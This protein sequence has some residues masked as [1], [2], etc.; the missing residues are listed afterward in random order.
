MW[1]SVH[2]L[3][4]PILQKQPEF[5]S[6]IKHQ[7]RDEL[8]IISHVEVG[9][10]CPGAV[11]CQ[12]GGADPHAVVARLEPPELAA[13]LAGKVLA[14]HAEMGFLWGQG[15]WQGHPAAPRAP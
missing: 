13:A 5:L 14:G 2:C 1:L 7:K 12:G 11:P 10:L 8:T 4:H 6:G 9:G 3:L 15:L